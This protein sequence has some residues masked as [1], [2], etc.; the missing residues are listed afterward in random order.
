MLLK[1]ELKTFTEPD[2]KG[3]SFKLN[4]ISPYVLYMYNAYNNYYSYFA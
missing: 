2:N 1:N 4:Y 3:L